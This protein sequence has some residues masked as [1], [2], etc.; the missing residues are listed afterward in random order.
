MNEI[1]MSAMWTA[2]PVLESRFFKAEDVANDPY[3]F[4]KNE[5]RIKLRVTS[6]YAADVYDFAK[7]DSIMELPGYTGNYNKPMY[8][9]STNN[10]STIR[11]DVETGKQALDLIRVVPNPY[12]GY[13]KFERIQIDNI[14]KF[15]NLPQKCSISIYALNGTLVKRINKD[16][17]QTSVDWYLK[18]TYGIPIAGGVYIVHVNAYELGQRT[19]KFMGILRPLDLVSF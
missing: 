11:G 2:I 6:W 5:V 17:D 14:V 4:I 9:F 8:R 7:P 16:N 18:N 13:S 1:Y 15:T 3:G 19:I 10:I 12:Y